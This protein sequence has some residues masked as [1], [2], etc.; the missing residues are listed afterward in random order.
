MP[1]DFGL[2]PNAALTGLS[3]AEQDSLQKQA[4]SQFLLGSLLSNDPGVG[5]RAA[6]G[7]PEQ[8]TTAQ[9]NILELRQKA[10]DRQSIAD[11]QNKYL[12]TQFNE[13]SPEFRGPVTPD[14]ES[15]QNELVAARSQGLPFNIQNAL[16]DVLRL[17]TAAQGPIRETISSL[18]PKAQGDLLLNPNMNILRGLPTQNNGVVSQYNPLTRGYSAAPVQNYMES[19]IL[20]TPPE[21]SPNT[22]LVPVQGGGVEQQLIPGAT[23]SVNAIA[24][25]KALGEAAGQTETVRNPV[26]GEMELVSRESVLNPTRNNRPNVNQPNLNQPNIAQGNFDPNVLPES[27]SGAVV[28]AS[29]GRQTLDK[30]IQQRFEIFSTEAA[31]K[32]QTAGG[33]RFAGQQLYNLADRIQNNKLTGIKAEVYSYMS[34]I[35]G[36]GNMFEQEVV[37]VT[38]M[39]Q[40]IKKAQLETTAAQKGSSS[41]L[42]ATNIEKSYAQITDPGLATKIASTIEIAQADKDDAK[43]QFVEFYRGNPSQIATAWNNSPLNGSIFNHPKFNQLV[44]EQVNKWDQGGRKNAPVLPAGFQ[45]GTSKRTGQFQVKRP[46]GSTYVIGQ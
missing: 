34:V 22:R 15:S 19:R 33:R 20:S 35:P 6:M 24:R 28:E 4:T 27:T 9:K 1:F 13:T 2:L 16:Q 5:Y 3:Q 39:L 29:P 25:A 7:V 32:A 36:V 18:Q 8:Y 26:T 43:N 17:P 31:N 40:N 21:I 23:A 14:V 37:D 12:P 10:A 41:N 42:D 11:F 44:T 38:N 45:F 30:G 46:D